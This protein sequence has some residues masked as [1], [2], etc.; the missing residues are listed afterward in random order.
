MGMG[1][2]SGQAGFDAKAYYNSEREQLSIITHEY[3]AEIAER[4]LLGD[5]YPEAASTNSVDLSK[6]TVDKD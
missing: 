4:E 2:G 1:V 3:I 6:L 5:R